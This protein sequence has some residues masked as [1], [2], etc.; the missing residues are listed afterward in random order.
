M[1]AKH[2]EKSINMQRIEE[3]LWNADD[4]ATFLKVSRSWV[5]QHAASGLLPKMKIGGNLRFD[6]RAIR[7]WAGITPRNAGG[8]PIVD[9]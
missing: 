7:E 9:H 1:K 4:V 6:P 3:N 8:S 5:Y 2:E